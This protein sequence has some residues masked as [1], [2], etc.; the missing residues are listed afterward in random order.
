MCFVQLRIAWQDATDGRFSLTGFHPVAIP[1][2]VLLGCSASVAVYVTW[3]W[4]AVSGA[5]QKI[6]DD[7]ASGRWW[8]G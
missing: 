2:A 5:L 7:A 3:C 8:I 4:P 6:M 1:A